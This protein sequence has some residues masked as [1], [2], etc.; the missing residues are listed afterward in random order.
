MRIHELDFVSENKDHRIDSQSNLPKE[1]LKSNTVENLFSQ[2][3]DL[4]ARLKVTLRRLSTLEIEN[5]KLQE[6]NQK[7]QITQSS[8]TDQMLVYKEKDRILRNKM[9]HLERDK[10]RLSILSLSLEKTAHKLQIDLERYKRYHEKVK[11]QVKPY[12]SELKDYSLNLEKQIA[13]LESTLNQKE[14]LIKELREQMGEVSKNARF[15]MELQQKQFEESVHQYEKEIQTSENKLRFFNTMEVD[16]ISAKNAL[17]KALERKDHLENELIQV[18]RLKEDQIS[19][20]SLQYEKLQSRVSELSRQNQKLGIE[21]ADL[22]IKVIEDQD[23]IKTLKSEKENLQE[24]LESL[25]IMW[26]AKNEE[27]EKIKNASKALERLNIELS[28]EVN[29]NRKT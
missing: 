19:S 24:Q 7:S 2:N 6:E 16:F 23:Q 28:K 21:H 4:M 26:N 14:T 25:R 10:E 11:T 9:D 13:N 12:L 8:V 3:D 5:Q 1:I 15:Q 27:V 22:Q 18:K 29:S 20:H 17:A